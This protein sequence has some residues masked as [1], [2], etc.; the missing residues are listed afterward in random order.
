MSR[1]TPTPLGYGN[2]THFL[3]LEVIEVV[4]DERSS[5]GYKR[6]NKEKQRNLERK[7]K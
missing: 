5:K 7:D 4:S 1:K 6:R 2:S 3:T